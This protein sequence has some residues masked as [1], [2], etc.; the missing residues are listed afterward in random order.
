[1]LQCLQSLY[2][3]D[4]LSL[5][6]PPSARLP[7]SLRTFNICTKYLN[8]RDDELR[9]PDVRL[10]VP[11]R[12]QDLRP[13]PDRQHRGSDLVLL[14]ALGVEDGKAVALSDARELDAGNGVGTDER[15]GG[16]GEFLPD[17]G[18]G[19]TSD[20]DDG[21]GCEAPRDNGDGPPEEVS[22]ELLVRRGEARK[23]EELNLQQGKLVRGL[24]SSR[25]CRR[26]SWP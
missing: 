19:G 17:G 16:A 8:N 18:R 26:G 7:S 5:R 11:S 4:Y 10:M 25:C 2:T 24:T 13:V 14:S 3:N 23:Y 6:I 1:M 20:R 22:I 12:V 21:D 9:G 15:R